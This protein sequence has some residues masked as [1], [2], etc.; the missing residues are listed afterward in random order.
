MPRGFPNLLL[1]KHRLVS[2]AQG[3]NL[4]SIF[5][6]GARPHPRVPNGGRF[7]CL[8]PS[9]LERRLVAASRSLHE[10]TPMTAP[11]PLSLTYL[12]LTVGFWRR[13]NVQQLT[14]KI[15]LSNFFYYH[16]FSFVLLELKPFVLSGKSWGNNSEKV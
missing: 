12:V 3:T 1:G 9:V 2:G 14:C 5:R 13:T 8:F 15:D 10:A 6:S 16:F 11:G 7:Y 4:S